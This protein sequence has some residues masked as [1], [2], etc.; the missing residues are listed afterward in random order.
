MSVKTAFVAS[1]IYDLEEAYKGQT[2]T[3]KNQIDLNR[4]IN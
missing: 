4:T 2:L 1:L 3:E